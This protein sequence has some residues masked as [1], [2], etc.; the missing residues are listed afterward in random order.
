MSIFP[1]LEVIQG[2]EPLP[3][4]VVDM[5]ATQ[6]KNAVQVLPLLVSTRIA[7]GVNT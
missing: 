2:N 4:A 5:V 3:I 7:I 6:H 1:E